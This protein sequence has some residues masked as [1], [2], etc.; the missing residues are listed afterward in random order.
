MR[1]RLCRAGSL[2]CAVV[3]VQPG[4]SAVQESPEEQMERSL[5]EKDLGIAMGERLDVTQQCVLAS[6]KLP[7]SWAASKAL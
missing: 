6:Q 5:A 3:G 2:V 1:A 7:T 4:T